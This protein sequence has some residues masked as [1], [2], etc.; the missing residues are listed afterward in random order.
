MKWSNVTPKE[1]IKLIKQKTTPDHMYNVSMNKVKNTQPPEW[2]KELITT[3]KDI[4][5]DVTEIKHDIIRIE[6]KVDNNTEMIKKNHSMIKK[7][8]PDLF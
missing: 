7:A 4:K 2:A 5:Q 8:H 3:V 1:L 6:S